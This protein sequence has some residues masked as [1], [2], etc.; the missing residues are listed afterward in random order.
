MDVTYLKAVRSNGLLV[1]PGLSDPPT[2][3]FAAEPRVFEAVGSPAG[4]MERLQQR[5]ERAAD[6]A[7][8]RARG[9]RVFLLEAEG[10]RLSAS[11]TGASRARWEFALC[12]D[13]DI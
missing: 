8:T 11:R 4:A 12:Y 6:E 2:P 3:A 9:G 5:V 1:F 13:E 10:P 7:R